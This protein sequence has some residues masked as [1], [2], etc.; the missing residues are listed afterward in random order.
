MSARSATGT[1][2]LSGS[3][4]TNVRKTCFCFA[5]TVKVNFESISQRA[6]ALRAEADD[7]TQTCV[8]LSASALLLYL[9]WR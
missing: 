1:G 6:S 5:G 8:V 7:M 4:R 2:E 3:L 9:P